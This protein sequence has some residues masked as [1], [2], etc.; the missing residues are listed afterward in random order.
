[1]RK[2]TFANPVSPR[3]KCIKNAGTGLLENVNTQK[4]LSGEAYIRLIF[5]K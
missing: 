5:S 3:T 1:M 2:I 4:G